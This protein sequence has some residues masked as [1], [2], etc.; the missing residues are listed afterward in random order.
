MPARERLPEHHADRPD[1]GCLRRLFAEQTLRRDVGERAGNVPDRGQRVELLH[2]G[3]PEVDQADVDAVA[4]GEQ[5]VRRL[6]VTVDDPA[7]VRVRQR[8]EQL[9]G[10]LDCVLVAELAGRDRLAQ[11]AAGDV[12]VGDVDVA[13]IARERVDPLA[14]RV[15]QG[16]GGAGLTLG[17][18]SRLLPSRATIFRATS[19]PVSSSR[20]SQTWPIPPEPSGRSGRYRPRMSS[21]ATA[22]DDTPAFTPRP[23]ELLFPANSG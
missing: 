17:A 22:A 8:L 6:H 11:R 16:R 19:R 23:G 10:G 13:R 18:V 1:V 4:L 15:A 21:C 7:A 14:P 3:E 12:L 5:H 2:L 20:A 9:G